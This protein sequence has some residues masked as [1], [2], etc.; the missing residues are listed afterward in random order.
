MGSKSFFSIVIENINRRLIHCS[1]PF[2]YPTIIVKILYKL[3]SCLFQ[4]KVTILYR[5]IPFTKNRPFIFLKKND[6]RSSTY[7]ENIDD[8]AKFPY[9]RRIYASSFLRTRT[10]QLLSCLFP[11]RN[12]NLLFYLPRTNHRL[13]QLYKSKDCS[14]IVLWHWTET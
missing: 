10:Y 1:L 14:I 2:M 13:F 8:I 12:R 4:L 3:T 11:Y 6:M 7:K 5:L 9:S